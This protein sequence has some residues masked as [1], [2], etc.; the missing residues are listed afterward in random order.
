MTVC[1]KHA[2]VLPSLFFLKPLQSQVLKSAINQ[3][4]FVVLKSTH[5]Y[6]QSLAEIIDISL[7]SHLFSLFHSLLFSGYLLSDLSGCRLWV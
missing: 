7:P 3:T 6:Y 2:P 1:F 5:E 4:L